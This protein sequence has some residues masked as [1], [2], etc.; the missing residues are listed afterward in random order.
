MLDISKSTPLSFAKSRSESSDVCFNQLIGLRL[1]DPEGNLWTALLKLLFS[2]F[3]KLPD[4]NVM[5]SSLSVDINLIWSKFIVNS[6]SV[7][8]FTSTALPQTIVS[9]WNVIAGAII[10][11]RS[12]LRFY[13]KKIRTLQ[14][15]YQCCT[16][17]LITYF[18]NTEDVEKYGSRLLPFPSLFH[19][20]AGF[21]FIVY[22]Y[23]WDILC[24]N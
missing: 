3:S 6:I 12:N 11:Q 16:N 20:S 19:S 2:I 24:D 14:L 1:W 21:S 15:S 7:M 13:I 4:N 17:I 10:K 23:D 18:V 22:K 9:V 5:N 8:Q